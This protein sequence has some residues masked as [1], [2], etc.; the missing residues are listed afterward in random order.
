MRTRQD[1]RKKNAVFCPGGVSISSCRNQGRL[2]RGGK[3]CL[4]WALMENRVWESGSNIR[5]REVGRE[6]GW[7]GRWEDGQR[8]GATQVLGR[9]GTCKMPPSMILP[10]VPCSSADHSIVSTASLIHSFPQWG[11][12]WHLRQESSS[13][14]RIALE[15]ARCLI[16]YFPCWTNVNCIP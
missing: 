5:N 4:S 13:S 11:H 14:C 15:M 3:S 9:V 8:A 16:S 10:H 7:E 2:E 12:C 1:A 6:R